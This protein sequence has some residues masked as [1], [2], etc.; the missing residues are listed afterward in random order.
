[1]RVKLILLLIIFGCATL[2]MCY[3]FINQKNTN[4]EL[5]RRLI[6]TEL[7]LNASNQDKALLVSSEISK[8]MPDEFGYS[9][10]DA[11]ISK[12]KVNTLWYRGKEIIQ[13][14]VI[15]DQKQPSDQVIQLISWDYKN[16]QPYQYRYFDSY[17]NAIQISS[18]KEEQQYVNPFSIYFNRFCGEL[19]TTTQI[20]SVRTVF[21]QIKGNSCIGLNAETANFEIM[22]STKELEIIAKKINAWR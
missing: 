20:N 6:E 4:N 10:V 21:L 8:F 22:R 12:M 11:D 19:S 2:I 17:L 14:T 18:G 9:L 3:A 15:V 1:M 5:Q 16:V 13:R 7:K